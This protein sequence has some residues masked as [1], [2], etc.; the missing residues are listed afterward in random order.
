M[1]VWIVLKVI[2]ISASNMV[3]GI[4]G[5]KSL[6][7]CKEIEELLKQAEHNGI[8]TEIIQLKDQFFIPCNGCKYCYQHYQCACEDD[9]NALYQKISGSNA[10]FI[11][12]AHYAPIPAKLS[13]LLEKMEQL[14]FLHWIDDNNYQSP[15]YGIPV[16]IISHGGSTESWA[17]DEYYRM[18]NY[19]INNALITIQMNV[20]QVNGKPGISV[21]IPMDESAHRYHF[22]A[23][24]EELN[25]L[26]AK[27]LT[28]A[29]V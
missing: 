9:F 7:I 15:V 29:R 22:E 19:P 11:V 8:D 12:S 24:R 10:V 4:N 3:N 23:A 27:V 26:V 1:G 16:G 17:I 25:A 18:V 6:A 14:S 21:G 20:I 5:G 28:N 2:C 13:M